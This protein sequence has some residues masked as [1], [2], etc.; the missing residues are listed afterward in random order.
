MTFLDLLQIALTAL[1]LLAWWRSR[2]KNRVV[3]IRISALLLLASV[4]FSLYLDRWQS[5]L[6]L[7]P[8]LLAL[9]PPLARRS[10]GKTTAWVSGTLLGLLS[11]ASVA[12]LYLFPIRPLPTPDGHYAVGVRTFEL[13]DES[14]KGVMYASADEPRKLLVRVWYP[15]RPATDASPLPYFSPAEAHSTAQGMGS[16]MG[17]A[18]LLSHVRH[19]RTN[20]YA[21][22]PLHEDMGR[23]PVLFFSHGYT[24]F[25][26]QNSVLMEKLA[27]HGYAVYAVQHTYDASPTVFANG[28]IAPMDPELVDS[29]RKGP[30]A[31]GEFPAVMIKAFTARALDDRLDAQLINAQENLARKSRIV[32]SSAP[33]WVADQVFVH[34]RLQAGHVPS[35]VA[36]VVAASDFERTGEIGMSFGGSTAGALCLVDKRCAALVNLDGG[37]F[38]FSPFAS[39]IPVPMLMLHSDISLFYGYFKADIAEQ[40]QRSFNDFSYERFEHAGQRADIHRLKI[41]GVAHNGLTDLAWMARRPLR[42]NLLGT[43]PTEIMLD[44]PNDF[45]LGF[46]DKYLRGQDNGFPKPQF[47]RYAG[48]AMPYDNTPVRQWWLAK[49]EAERQAFSARIE[50]LKHAARPY[51]YTPA[52][53]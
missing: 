38:H 44:A 1:L 4:A 51:M 45:V 41:R 16:L 2:L 23:L 49:S 48:W 31:N 26:W 8:V 27:S 7:L 3:L 6:G 15:A 36:D 52:Q 43:A 34:D 11:I 25:A 9:T 22:A 40:D 32:V 30:E 20:S 33:T 19:V 28:D 29:F 37:D 39:D 46:F 14:R 35:S 18:P 21:N 13:V 12:L 10:S 47:Q 17:F 53:P 5:A 42:D 24:G 50:Q